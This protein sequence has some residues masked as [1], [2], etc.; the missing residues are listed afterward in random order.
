MGH[1]WII[2]TIQNAMGLLWRH[3]NLCST[4]H[5]LRDFIV[6]LSDITPPAPYGTNLVYDRGYRRCGQYR[7][8]APPYPTDMTCDEGA[9]GRYL[10][11]YV[12]S[13][14]HMHICEIEAY[15]ICE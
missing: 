14:S 11:I 8:T 1:L 15:G 5:Q 13:Y 10:Y 9:I 4:G 6:E 7:G 12:P 3:C 2:L